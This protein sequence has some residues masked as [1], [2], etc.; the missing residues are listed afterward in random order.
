MGVAYFPEFER[1]VTGF[2]PS[3]AV[4]GKSLARAIKRLDEIC[5]HLGTAP[6]F[7]FYSESNEEAFKTIGKPVPPGLQDNPI[8]WS[9][10]EQGLQTIVSLIK[11]L[12]DHPAELPDAPSILEDLESLRQVLL[13]AQEHRTRFRLRIDI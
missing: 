9:E 6:L 5:K 3:A 2:D 12:H 8:H 10:P 7:I 13:K 1:Q 4:C 11:Y